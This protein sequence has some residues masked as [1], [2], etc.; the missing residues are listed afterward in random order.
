MAGALLLLAAGPAP[1]SLPNPR[2]TPGAIDPA[3]T[4]DNIAET[5]CRAG[6]TRGVRPPEAYTE[7]L[8]RQQMDEYGYRGEHLRDFEQDHLVSLGLGG[9]PTDP[10]NEWPEPWQPADGW[11]ADVKDALELRLHDLVCAGR[12]PLAD[13]QRAI[14]T[15]WIAAYRRYGGMD[16]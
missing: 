9:H 13:A 11:G 6:Y 4:Q 2:L 1:S 14:A 3:V 12:L 5:I 7:A 16:R 15:D 8:K 10:R